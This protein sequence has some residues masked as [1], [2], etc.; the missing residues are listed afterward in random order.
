[1]KRRSSVLAVLLLSFLPVLCFSVPAITR[2][3]IRDHIGLLTRQ[4][5][6]EISRVRQTV[7]PVH[8]SLQSSQYTGPL[9][10]NSTLAP[11][12]NDN[13][14][15]RG[16]LGGPAGMAM[17]DNTEATYETGEPYHFFYGF[18]TNTI[19]YSWT[20]PYTGTFTFDTRNSAVATLLAIYRGNSLTNL[21][22]FSYGLPFYASISAQNGAVYQIAV[23]GASPNDK[24]VT[25]L[26]YYPDTIG[27]TTNLSN[28][29]NATFQLIPAPDG[30]IAYAVSK[31]VYSVS[32][33][34]N[35][36]GYPVNPA[37]RFSLI[38]QGLNIYDR[39]NTALVVNAWP[40]G[41][42]ANY[43]LM[44]FDGKQALLYNPTTETLLLY[45]L[46]RR[47]LTRIGQQSVPNLAA[48]I[49][50]GS[51]IFS[52]QISPESYFYGLPVMGLQAFDK[53]LKR[54]KWQLLYEKGAI[55]FHLKTGYATRY[56]PQP[57]TQQVT[58]YKKGAEQN[59]TLIDYSFY[60]FTEFQT[61]P[62]GNLLFWYESDG[63]PFTTN[64]PITYI[65]RKGDTVFSNR[66]L[67]DAGNA[68]A[69]GGFEKSRLYIARPNGATQIATGY[70]LGKTIVQTGN[71]AL[72]DYGIADLADGQFLVYRYTGSDMEGFTEYDKNVKKETWN[73]PLS[74][75]TL[76]YIGKGTFLRAR[77]IPGAGSTN[78]LLKIF[79][80]K[81]T[82]ADH[83]IVM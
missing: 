72:T 4:I 28:S 41:A 52:I 65:S 64:S 8:T 75:G 13:F 15:N 66:T 80:R 48:G 76:D 82:I 47:G 16:Y 18:G 31:V 44:D 74:Q 2:P 29:T 67:P 14:A 30:S 45:R 51:Y 36:Y 21:T 10:I 78:Y 12:A 27:G 77:M 56:L 60:G 50:Y 59:R 11:P 37:I 70:K 7:L 71:Q 39:N 25:H 58:G 63:S 20:A 55:D 5:D 38:S 24:G 68:W 26:R 32:S 40:D 34:T 61:D 42:G 49:M 19:W 35:R 69:F 62:I 73:E 22:R 54:M 1:M 79:N 57:Y 6:S 9:P 83:Q 46:T 81:K 43:V 23:M 33:P 3:K 17:V 53:R